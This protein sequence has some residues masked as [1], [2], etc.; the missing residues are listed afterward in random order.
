MLGTLAIALGLVLALGTANANAQV[1]L[2]EPGTS[3]DAQGQSQPRTSEPATPDALIEGGP[4]G[5]HGGPRPTTDPTVAVDLNGLSTSYYRNCG[6]WVRWDSYYTHC[7]SA[8]TIKIRVN[9]WYGANYR[10]IWVGRG[11]TNL[12]THPYLQGAGMITNAWCI[13]N[14]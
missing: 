3:T 14:C 11:T 5:P 13:E 9:F 7:G 2:A 4:Y 10:D 6:F 8:Y 1:A 12:S